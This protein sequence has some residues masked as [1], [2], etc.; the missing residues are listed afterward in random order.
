[1]TDVNSTVIKK[2]SPRAILGSIF[3]KSVENFE[4][5]KSFLEFHLVYISV[6]KIFLGQKSKKLQLADFEQ[7]RDFF[8]V[9]Q[10][11]TVLSTVLLASFM[12]K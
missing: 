8:P 5:K 4:K 12:L 11:L 1:M 7:I 6:F 10:F 2:T 3:S 9:Y